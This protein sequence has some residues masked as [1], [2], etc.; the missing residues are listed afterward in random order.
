[1]DPTY[2]RT[3]LGLLRLW[4]EVPS[5]M[6]QNPEELLRLLLSWMEAPDPTNRI[7]P[8]AFGLMMRIKKDFSNTLTFDCYLLAEYLQK[9]SK[10][11][12]HLQACLLLLRP[13]TVAVTVQALLLASDV[14]SVEDMMGLWV[15]LI[16]VPAM[17]P[18]KYAMAMVNMDRWSSPYPIYSLVSTFF[19][20]VIRQ[21]YSDKSAING[22]A[23]W[24]VMTESMLRTLSAKLHDPTTAVDGLR[25]LLMILKPAG[26]SQNGG[27]GQGSIL[28]HGAVAQIFDASL[29]PYY[30]RLRTLWEAGQVDSLP[31]YALTL[32]TELIDLIRPYVG[33]MTPPYG[34]AQVTTAAMLGLPPTAARISTTPPPIPGAEERQGSFGMQTGPLPTGAAVMA[35]TNYLLPVVGDLGVPLQQQQ[36]QQLAQ[37]PTQ[38]KPQ[39]V[40]VTGSNG[41]TV[42]FRKHMVGIQNYNNTCYLGVFLQMLFL[43]DAFCS[44]VYGFQLQEGED[45]KDEDYEQG[46]K[47]LD[48]LRLLFARMLLTPYAY[49][50][51]SDF[52]KVL[53]PSFRTGEEQDTTESA[54]WILDK[55]GGCKQRLV[56]DIFALEL[57]HKTQCQTCHTISTRLE[58]CTDIGLSVPREAEVL[59]QGSLDVNGLLKTWAE[60]EEMTGNNQY[61]CD[62]CG[63]KRDAK[64]WVELSSA[65]PTHLILVLYRFSFDIDSCDFKKEKTVVYPDMD[66]LV[67]GET[68]QNGHYITVGRRSEAPRGKWHEYNDSEVTDITKEEVNRLLSGLERPNTSAYMLF[69]RMKGSNV[70]RGPMPI[71][72][73]KI[74]AEARAVEAKAV[75]L[76][77]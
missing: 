59:G 72:D 19:R 17:P 25:Q 57:V 36:H 34:S 33:D 67:S 13:E 63:C 16:A 48:G 32:M 3:P 22:G 28:L 31:P 52:I 73:P 46:K 44:S 77:D 53:P 58:P 11:N 55:L 1:M 47:I 2:H 56:G 5:T 21:C 6:P 37:P 27:R 66:D 10:S 50:E 14:E 26:T 4:T 12:A 23:D 20:C 75:H 68:I 64:R 7:A 41:E 40:Y 76:N 71:V 74:T 70:P 43:T 8:M 54:R 61:S 18:P 51:I 45:L 62:N 15:K 69:Y 60:P 9:I 30:E 29:L 39:L 38:T 24:R 49:V 35:P 65:P 42:K